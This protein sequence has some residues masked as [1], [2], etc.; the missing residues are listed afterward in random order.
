M[1]SRCHFKRLKTSAPALSIPKVNR[2]FFSALFDVLSSQLMTIG[3]ILFMIF[4]EQLLTEF[5]LAESYPFTRVRGYMLILLFYLLSL[6][7]HWQSVWF[8]KQ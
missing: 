3:D 1:L 6:T 7:F 4:V 2:Q 5:E 8:S